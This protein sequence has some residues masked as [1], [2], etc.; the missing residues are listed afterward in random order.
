LD[1]LANVSFDKMSDAQK[2]AVAQELESKLRALL[3]APP[4]PI[5]FCGDGGNCSGN[6]KCVKEVGGKDHCEC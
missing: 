5:T 1:L 4:A 2:E 3:A 6:G